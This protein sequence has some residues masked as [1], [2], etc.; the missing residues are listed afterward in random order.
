[1]SQLYDIVIFTAGLKEYT[2]KVMDNIDTKK[3]I[4][5]VLYR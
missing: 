2:D 1:M 3:R 4:K 5:H